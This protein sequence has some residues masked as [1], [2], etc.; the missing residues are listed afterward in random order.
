MPSILIRARS[1]NAPIQ[2]GIAWW[3]VVVV[4]DK[5]HVASAVAAVSITGDNTADDS[6]DAEWW[7][8]V[9]VPITVLSVGSVDARCRAC[10]VFAELG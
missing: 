7:L 3:P 10:P 1:P 2:I 4:V 6:P 8:H 5:L 9:D